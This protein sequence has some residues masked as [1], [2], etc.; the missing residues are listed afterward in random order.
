[1]KRNSVFRFKRFDCRH[2]KGSMKIGVDAVLVG[3]WASV[4]DADN[5]LDVGTGCGVI[6]LMCAQ[7][8]DKARIMAIDIDHASIAE[9]EDNFALSPWFNRLSAVEIGYDALDT[10]IRF[11][12][13]VSNPPYFDSGVINPDTPRMRARHQDQLCPRKL[14]ERGRSLLAVD[15]KIAMIIP[16]DQ[17]FSLVEDAR[18]LNYCLTRGLLVKGH[19][20]APAKRVLLEFSYGDSS[21]EGIRVDDLPLL[22]LETAPGEPTAEHRELCG[23]F[24]LKY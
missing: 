3:S 23:A 24:Y 2:G 17:R 16:E 21:R 7:R 6:A 15:G 13:I 8:N 11:D 14:L 18:R 4:D 1:M 9:A 12:L 19:P 20:E 22:I 10:D 5:I